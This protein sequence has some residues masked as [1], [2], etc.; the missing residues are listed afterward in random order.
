MKV[1][2][3]T[4]NDPF[5]NGWSLLHS[6]A[7]SHCKSSMPAN[8]Y[9]IVL[10]FSATGTFSR[11]QWGASSVCRCFP[12]TIEGKLQNLR[13]DVSTYLEKNPVSCIPFPWLS[14]IGCLRLVIGPR[15]YSIRVALD[16][17]VFLHNTSINRVW[18]RDFCLMW[19]RFLELSL[20]TV[21]KRQT[22][23]SYTSQALR[24]SVCHSHDAR[25]CRRKEQ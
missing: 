3:I 9:F 25:K 19:S 8:S 22:S 12:S 18:Q 15:R 14:T 13:G 16:S 2:W 24:S 10:D 11:R 21:E 17:I 6:Q 4:R 5:H 1:H 20:T 23:S 7:S